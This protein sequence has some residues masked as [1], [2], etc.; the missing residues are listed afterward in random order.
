MATLPY[1]LVNI[2]TGPKGATEVDKPETL[3]KL[4]SRA[5]RPL[6][7]VGPRLLNYKL[8][9]KEL[10]EYA[11]MLAR[12]GKIP[13]CATAHTKK[14][15]LEM[16]QPPESTYDAAEIVHRLKDPNWKGVKGEGNHDLVIFFG[17]RTD[18]GNQGLSTLKH[19]A[20]HLRTMTLCKF[21]YPHADF[22]L[23][24]IR[25]DEQW[26]EILEKLISE[27]AKIN[28][29]PEEELKVEIKA[30]EEEKVEKF[31]VDMGPQYE[32]ERV[33]KDDMYVEF[34]GPKV[35][36]KCEL[37][38]L[39][40]LDEITDGEVIVEG[41]DI[42]DMEPGGSYPLAIDAR[43]AGEKLEKDMEPVLERRMHDFCNYIHGLYHMNQQ[44]SIWIRLHK[45]AYEKGL[46]SLETIGKMIIFGY[47]STFSLIEKMSIR[48][49]TDPEKVKEFVQHAV[50]IYEARRKRARELT[51]EDVDEFYG[52]V[53][54]Q[55]FA[56]SHVC[57]I[58]PDRIAN[59]GAINWFD[60]RAAS[61]MDPE[62]P[63]FPVPKGEC[64][65]KI[66]GEYSGANEVVKKRSL[67]ATERVWIHSALQYP[68]TSC[69]CF[70][71]ILFYI[72]ECDAFGI[73]DRDFKGTTPLGIPFSTMAGE[74]SGGRQVEGMCGMAFEYMYSKKFFQYDGGWK[75][76]VWM[77]KA[78]KERYKDAIPEDMYDKIATEED[79]T[80]PNEL[81]SWLEEREHPWITGE[82]QE[83][84]EELLEQDEE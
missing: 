57:I 59:C 42:K 66:R 51:E 77:P 61:K 10:M 53:L 78:I 16:G 25:K 40:G 7:V 6:L 36:F 70:Q 64:L 11:I 22:S 15:L 5:K 82:A 30:I 26:K 19:F 1:H 18:F 14:R 41:I 75:R 76:I 54:C 60:G 74:A 12:A 13:I 20:P 79:T 45:D 3:A 44:D 65:G 55:S 35:D 9:D 50:E 43:V 69:G 24:N 81:V 31:P 21:Y 2:L 80:D 71:A 29:V 83:E 63:I 72:P 4:I 8:G 68:H 48:F 34:G 56:P 84:L 62:G 37:I 17:F 73:V 47:K 52:C 58:T 32:G 49:I 27:L 28:N 39:Y 23:P 33:R 46:N 67:G 38:T